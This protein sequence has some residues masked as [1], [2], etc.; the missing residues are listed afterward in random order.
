MGFMGVVWGPSYIRRTGG[1]NAKTSVSIFVLFTSGAQ[2]S[3]CNML[4]GKEIKAVKFG[5]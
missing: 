5:H 2:A 1:G 4:R 3:V